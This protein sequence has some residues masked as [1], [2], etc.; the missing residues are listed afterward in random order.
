[1]LPNAGADGTP[2]GSQAD[3]W[4]VARCRDAGDDAAFGELVRRYRT[5]VF[6]L[7]VSILGQ[8]FAPDAE[9]VAQD[10]MLRV[11]HALGSFRGEATFGSWIYRVAFNQALNV[12]ARVR[13]RAPHLSD[14]ALALAPARDRGPYEQLS[15]ARRQQAVLACVGELPEVYQSALRLHYWMGASVSEIARDARRARE[16]REVEPGPA[17]GGCCTRCW[18]SE[19]SMHDD[20]AIDQLLKD[21]LGAPPPGL[22]AGFDARVMRRLRP[23]RLTPAGRAVLVVYAVLAVAVA[24]W[25]MRDLRVEWIA[26]AVAIGVPMAAGWACTRARWLQAGSAGSRR[27]SAASLPLGHALRRAEQPGRH[28][29]QP[30]R[31]D[32]LEERGDGDEPR[33]P[34]R[35]PCSTAPPARSCRPGARR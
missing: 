18:S 1:M 21:A 7:V 5:P 14:Q 31:Q 35:S 12:K 19:V 28:V 8:E 4:L 32:A 6:R 29:E 25:A 34:V 30:R 16:H 11:Y 15:D 20:D 2:D 26:M 33:R 22:S 13:Y 23:R 3:E 9:D 10:V 24:A 17:A 27:R